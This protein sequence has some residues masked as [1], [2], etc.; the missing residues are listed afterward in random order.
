MHACTYSV[1]VSPVS[2][3]AAAGLGLSP[4]QTV[5]VGTR[6]REFL[7][8]E[9]SDVKTQQQLLDR[10]RKRAV[11]VSKQQQ[12]QQQQKQSSSNSKSSST[13]NSSSKRRRSSNSSSRKSSLEGL[14]CLTSC[15]LVAL[16][17]VCLLLFKHLSPSPFM[18]LSM[19][20]ALSL[21]V[22][23]CLSFCLSLSVSLSPPLSPFISRF[24]SLLLGICLCLF[25]SV[26]SSLRCLCSCLS[27]LSD[28]YSDDGVF[29]LFCRRLLSSHL[30]CLPVSSRG[31]LSVSSSS[32]SSSSVSS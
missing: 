9:K 29:C 4:S 19:S 28:A 17:S 25:L 6:A 20:L 18:S 8:N 13:S 1:H 26:F 11:K 15:S 23:L 5:V 14:H 7:Q 31:C 27:S 3:S 32:V 2:S 30:C 24:V 21:I 22:S 10:V 16:V 12:Q